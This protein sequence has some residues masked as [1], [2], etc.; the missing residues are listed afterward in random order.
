ME[1]GD[2]ALLEIESVIKKHG[3]WKCVKSLLASA[4]VVAAMW[5]FCGPVLG[6]G[7]HLLHHDSITYSVHHRNSQALIRNV[8]PSGAHHLDLVFGSAVS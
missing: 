6:L 3:A 8:A 2:M 1:T 7:W 5:L 4:L